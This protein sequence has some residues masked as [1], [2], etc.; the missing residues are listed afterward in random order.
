MLPEILIRRRNG[1]FCCDTILVTLF[2]DVSMM[3]LL[4][5]RRDWFF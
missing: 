4:K 3:A 1:K 5:W 2:G